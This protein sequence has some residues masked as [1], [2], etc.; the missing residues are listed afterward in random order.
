MNVRKTKIFIKL[1][2]FLIVTFLISSCY[3]ERTETPTKGTLS[4]LV[5]ESI[6]P[7]VQQLKEK[8]EELYVESKI[9]PTVTTSRE[10]IVQFFNVD[11]IRYIIVSRP[12]NQEE[13]TIASRENLEFYEYKIALGGV[14][15]IVNSQNP[16]TQLRTTQLDSIFQGL[17]LNWKLLG[18]KEN[19]SNIEVCFP[20][21]NSGV[22]EVVLVKILNGKRVTIPA[23]VMQSSKDIIKFVKSRKSAMAVIGINWLHNVDE[24]IQAVKIC[25]PN[26]PDSLGIKEK[27]FSPHQAYIY[28]GYYYLTSDV[29]IYSRVDM[30]SVGAGFTSFITSAQG[31]KIILNNGLVPATMPVRIVE[32]TNRSIKQ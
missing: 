20:D 23:T 29:Y 4:I 19:S 9:N 1:F 30:Y 26:A 21:Q 2:W 15:V 24:G 6:F 32:L 8:F 17:I 13:R 31:Q 27:Y 10:A 18:W 22:Y 14:A 16:I 3:H 25:N 12:L 28:Q 5:A 7:V 11:S